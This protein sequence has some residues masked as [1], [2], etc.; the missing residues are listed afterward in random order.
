MMH[1]GQGSHNHTRFYIVLITLVIGGIFLVLV[2][3]NTSSEFN[4]TGSS[5]GLFDSDNLSDGLFEEVSGKV[6]IDD[7]AILVNENDPEKI[8]KLRSREVNVLLSFDRIPTV[9]DEAKIQDFNVVFKNPGTPI[10]INDNYLELGLV[11]EVVMEVTGF[12][13]KLGFNQEEFSLQGKA[14]RIEVNGMTFSSK[15]EIGINLDDASYSYLAVDEIELQ[16]LN[17]PEGSGKLAVADK[18]NYLLEEEGLNFYSFVGKL[19]ID[20]GAENALEMEGVA[21]GMDVSGALLNLDV[22]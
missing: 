12:N 8:K 19:V 6:V 3:N 17:I 15:T 2:M 13:G 22:R 4:L 1:S 5:V 20:K 16:D 14:K 21:R 18:L 11:E 9:L 10:Q 7:E